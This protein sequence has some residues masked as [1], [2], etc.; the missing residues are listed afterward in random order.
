MA[1]SVPQLRIY[2]PELRGGICEGKLPHGPGS[3][4]LSPLWG[5]GTSRSI[6]GSGAPSA[7]A[8]CS[9]PSR[10]QGYVHQGMAARRCA[11]AALRVSTPH[12]HRPP[13]LPAVPA[14]RG[15]LQGS[16]ARAAAQLCF[17]SLPEKSLQPV[18]HM[19][20]PRAGP[21]RGRKGPGAGMGAAVTVLG[22]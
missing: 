11:R 8:R 1:G 13:G 16:L 10:S 19:A 5:L 6:P 7:P 18:L 20:L 12:E 22:D 3:V 21:R 9:P 2:F 14:V 17:C 4:P 15:G